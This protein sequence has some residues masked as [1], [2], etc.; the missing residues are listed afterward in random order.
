[1]TNNSFNEVIIYRPNFSALFF[2]F[3]SL[4]LYEGQLDYHYIDGGCDLIDSGAPLSSHSCPYS[5]VRFSGQTGIYS[6]RLW[7]CDRTD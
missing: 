2:F 3:F 4:A 1:M 5:S 6:L 7:S